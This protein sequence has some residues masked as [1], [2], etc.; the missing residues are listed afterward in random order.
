VK[1]GVRCEDSRSGRIFELRSV[2]DDSVAATASPNEVGHLIF[3]AVPKGGYRL[4]A[5]AK[6][7]ETLHW[8]EAFADRFDLVL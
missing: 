6:P 3:D 2:A 1:I 4:I 7:D 5:S 8:I